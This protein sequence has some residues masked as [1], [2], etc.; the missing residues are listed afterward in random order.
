MMLVP[1]F[2]NHILQNFY[3]THF[4]LKINYF[5]KKEMNS[6]LIYPKYALF[7]LHYFYSYIQTIQY[8]THCFNELFNCMCVVCISKIHIT[9]D[10]IDINT[11]HVSHS[12]SY[13]AYRSLCMKFRL[14]VIWQ[15]IEQQIKLYGTWDSI[16]L[17]N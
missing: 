9:N 3:N 14:V 1:T 11:F 7:S 13:F 6:F 15:W 5:F 2:F 8:W 4:I 16:Q 10:A 12:V 17:W